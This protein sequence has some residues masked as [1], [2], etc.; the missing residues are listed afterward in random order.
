MVS[1]KHRAMEWL[2]KRNPGELL[3]RDL[4]EL[5]ALRVLRQDEVGEAPPPELAERLDLSSY[6]HEGMAVH[7]LAPRGRP[8]ERTIFYLHGGGYVG[9]A[10]P[11]HWRYAERLSD[12]VS[13]R[14]VMPAY[15]VAPRSTWREAHP[16]VA[17]LFRRVAAESPDDLTLLGDS[18]G[19]GFALALAQQMVAESGPL[20]GRLVLISAWVDMSSRDLNLPDDPWISRD[21]L[22]LCARLWAG[23]DPLTIPALSPLLGSFDGLPPMLVLCGTKDVQLPQARA[24]VAAAQAAGI[25]VTYVEE[26]GLLHDYPV[27]N[28]PEARRALR[29]VGQFV[30]GES[31]K[32]AR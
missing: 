6:D 16:L 28:I 3:V 21:Y 26:R 18:A 2:V 9:H 17:G 14:V 1:L 7:V 23:D 11:Q 30:R 29:Q 15:P 22:A 31:V 8:A 32:V 20:P 5:R 10:D 27:L 25:P 12:H 24:L 19:A 4:E 13:A